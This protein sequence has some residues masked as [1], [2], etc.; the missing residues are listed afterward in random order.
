[1]SNVENDF[2]ETCSPGCVKNDFSSQTSFF[3][4]WTSFSHCLGQK[5]ASK[6]KFEKFLD[7]FHPVKA[8]QSFIT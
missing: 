6:P 3:M 2:D 1:M 4:F 5:Y 7:F 8:V